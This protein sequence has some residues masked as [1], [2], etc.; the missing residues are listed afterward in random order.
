MLILGQS[1]IFENTVEVGVAELKWGTNVVREIFDG[2]GYVR[3]LFQ[4]LAV[5]KECYSRGI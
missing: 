4:V 2:C 1:R 5:I 3:M